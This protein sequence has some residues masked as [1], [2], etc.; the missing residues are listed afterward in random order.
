MWRS[1]GFLMNFAVVLEGMTLIA[2]IVMLFGSLQ[3]RIAGK[4]VITGFLLLVAVLQLVSMSLISW[5]YD[6]DDRFFPGW[7]LDH[8]YALC[9]ASWVLS[10][11]TAGGIWVVSNML[12]ME[13]DYE[14]IPDNA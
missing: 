7:E 1:V 5:I 6:Y 4:T 10:V 12:P 9:T 13:G 3:K 8:S 2:F 14:L 11:A